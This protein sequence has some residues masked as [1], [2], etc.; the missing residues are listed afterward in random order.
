[1]TTGC[2]CAATQVRWRGVQG[3]SGQ[4]IERMQ[5]VA[6]GTAGKHTRPLLLFP[7]VTNP[8]PSCQEKDQKKPGSQN[9]ME[10]TQFGMPI[11][12]LPKIL[13]SHVAPCEQLLAVQNAACNHCQAPILGA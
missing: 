12:V 13:A 8:A 1:M 7:E 6:D 10:K 2:M 9:K 3:D 5:S 4:V 11:H